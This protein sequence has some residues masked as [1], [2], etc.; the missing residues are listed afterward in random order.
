MEEIF[1]IKENYTMG[2][3]SPHEFLNELQDVL[4]RVGA[5]GELE[6]TINETLAPLADFI[7]ADILNAVGDSKKQI[8]DFLKK[9]EA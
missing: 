5:H 7:V 2:F 1:E 4:M 8:K 9:E 6:N 3:I